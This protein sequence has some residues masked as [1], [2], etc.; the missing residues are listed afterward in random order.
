MSATRH[1]RTMIPMQMPNQCKRKPNHMSHKTEFNMSACILDIMY[2]R[3]I[4]YNLHCVYPGKKNLVEIFELWRWQCRFVGCTPTLQVQAEECQHCP[5]ILFL[6]LMVPRGWIPII[7]WSSNF[8]FT[9]NRRNLFTYLVKYFNMDCVFLV[10]KCIV[11]KLCIPITL[12]ILW[13]F[14]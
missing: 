8:S 12:V 10:Q 9:T 1:M 14:L 4:I 11:P 5:E 6:I 3:N 7:L 13:L 2:N